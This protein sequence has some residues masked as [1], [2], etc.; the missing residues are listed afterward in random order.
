MGTKPPAAV[1]VRISKDGRHDL[2][3]ASPLSTT[4]PSL[5][6]RAGGSAFTPKLVEVFG[7]GSTRQAEKLSPCIACTAVAAPSVRSRVF[8]FA[9][10]SSSM[11]R[12]GYRAS[13]SSLA[14]CCSK[15]LIIT[16]SS[17]NIFSSCSKWL[18][19]FISK[20]S[21]EGRYTSRQLG[22][23]RPEFFMLGNEAILLP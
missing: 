20:L 22:L 6:G 1:V 19:I 2:G 12:R 11:A 16:S 13:C 5:Q 14:K 8:V 21:S 7:P 9:I 3:D 17:S 10:P 23:A 15:S 4:T 18:F